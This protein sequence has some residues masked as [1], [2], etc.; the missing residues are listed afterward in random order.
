MRA[1]TLWEPW[2]TLVAHGL[3]H[4]ETRSW[5]TPFRG[6]LAIHAAKRPA[7]PSE[8]NPVIWDALNGIGYYKLSELPYGNVIGI[9]TMI[10]CVPAG[11]ALRNMKFLKIA[12]T[13]VHFGDFSFGRFAWEFSKVTR[14]GDVPAKGTQGFWRWGPD[15]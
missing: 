5:S 11:Q 13:E 1:I 9:A 7:V 12:E 14:I 8:L 3:K 6:E 15:L 2:A 4:Y 10:D